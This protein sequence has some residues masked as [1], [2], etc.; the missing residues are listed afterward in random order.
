MTQTNFAVDMGMTN[1]DL[2]LE[3]EHSQI[4][5]MLPNKHP[6][7][8]EQLRQA[9][10][11]V[12]GYLQS[13]MTVGVT[14]GRYRLLLEEVDGFKV[15][16]VNEMLALGL[17]GLALS[18]RRSGLVV[19]AGTGVAMVSAADDQVEH[20]TGSA[21][22]GGTLLGLSRIILGTDDV[23]E[24]DSLALAG[25]AAAV[26]IMLSEAVGGEVGR[27]PAKA[28]AVNLGKL[29][30]QGGFSRENLA[31]GLVR[32]VAQVIAVIAIN[33]SD[34]AGMKDIIL[35]GHLMDLESIRNEINLVG[36]FYNRKFVIPENPGFGTVMGV[37]EVLKRD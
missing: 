18:E 16:K 19:S 10:G 4:M 25:D 28:N 37:L 3:T 31:A 5:R 9:L 20:V 27:L 17:G 21:V 2:I 26:D 22:G 13:G 12:E 29:D 33:A 32:L 34:A 24:I 23:D 7:P 30:H 14:G 11:A 15:Q 1:I 35:V 6:E 8:I 36:E